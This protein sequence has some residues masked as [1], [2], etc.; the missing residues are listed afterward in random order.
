MHVHIMCRYAAA[1]LLA[2]NDFIPVAEGEGFD[3]FKVT[4][5]GANSAGLHLSSMPKLH[6]LNSLLSGTEHE[7]TFNTTALSQS[8]T[9][10]RAR[11][12]KKK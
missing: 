8:V 11:G 2:R 1:Y 5:I 9:R 7:P 3:L 4:N 10:Q 6:I 12:S